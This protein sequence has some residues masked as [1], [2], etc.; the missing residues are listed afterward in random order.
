[1]ARSS[2]TITEQIVV[3]NV[4]REVAP[5]LHI[6]LLEKQSS[7]PMLPL[8]HHWCQYR[9]HGPKSLLLQRLLNARWLHSKCFLS[10]LESL[11]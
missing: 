3:S 2:Q 6:Q 5:P 4:Q 9:F 7:V 1:M 10:C 11:R 8:L